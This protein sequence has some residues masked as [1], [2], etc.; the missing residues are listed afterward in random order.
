MH[1]FQ[2]FKAASPFH[3]ERKKNHIILIT[4]IKS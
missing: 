4:I 1:S 3:W 2:E